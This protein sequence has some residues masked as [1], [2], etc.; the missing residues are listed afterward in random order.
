MVEETLDA[1]VAQLPRIDA[2][3]QAQKKDFA[4]AM[5]HL[6]LARACTPI[7]A[8]RHRKRSMSRSAAAPM[9]FSSA[10]GCRARRASI[11]RRVAPGAACAIITDENVARLHLPTLQ[12]SLGRRRHSRTRRS[13]LS[14]AR[15]R[16]RLRSSGASATR[17][18]RRGSS[19][20][21]SSSRFGGGV[22]GDLAG[23]VAASVRRGSRFVQI[24]TTL[25]SQV[26]S[27]VGGKTGINS[28]HGKNL[29]RR[30]SPAVAGARRRRRAARRCRCASFAPA[31]PR[32]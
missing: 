16:N 9:T 32:S 20:A 2:A 31:M 22:V 19:G 6:H 23:F 12:Q 15:A 1:L 10:R 29:D 30:L 28:P 17:F 8:R 13:S 27:S 3:R 5:T 24:P 26:D 14:R 7:R 11:S 21:I 4:K 18:W 25:L